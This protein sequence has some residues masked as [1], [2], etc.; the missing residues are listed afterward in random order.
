MIADLQTNLVCVSNLLRRRHPDLVLG[1]ESILREHGVPLVEIPGTRDVWCRDYLP[2]Q[3]D[4]GRFVQF[5]YA[6]D[7]LSGRYRY[8]RVDG[9]IGPTL[10]Q[11]GRCERSDIV[12]DG[13]N[14]VGWTNRA[15]VCDKVFAENPG[16][17]PSELIRRLERLLEVERVIVIPTEPGDVLGHSDGVVRFIGPDLV[18]VNDYR[19]VD[20]RYR[21]ALRRALAGAGLTMVELPYKP[22]AAGTR[23]IPPAFGCYINYLR[24]DQLVVVPGYDLPED[25]EVLERLRQ[26]LPD[27][28][29]R[30]LDCAALSGDGGVLNCATW[31]I[32]AIGR[33]EIPRPHRQSHRHRLL[34]GFGGN[35]DTDLA[36][37]IKGPFP[38]RFEQC[39]ST[40]SIT[41][42]GGTLGPR[43][44]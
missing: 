10:P 1:L 27:S 24:V 6:P 12:L 11:V 17:K 35:C 2:V 9:E 29:V 21:L 22:K 36:C 23:G 34:D 14:V 8:L 13:G 4:V 41:G 18:L 15:I 32:R 7:Y 28:E 20:A 42:V 30:H 40:R 33:V 43:N 38:S 25:S 3:I 44:G 26:I 16:W 19:K 31:S 5:R 37:H 39:Q